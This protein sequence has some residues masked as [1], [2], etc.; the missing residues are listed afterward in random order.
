MKKEIKERILKLKEQGVV[1]Y[2]STCQASGMGLSAN[3]QLTISTVDTDEE[4]ELKVARAEREVASRNESNE[5]Y[6]Y[7]VNEIHPQQEEVINEEPV[8]SNE[9]KGILNKIISLLRAVGRG[10]IKD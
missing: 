4:I 2:I 6:K 5:R 10:A 3:I 9:R 1:V 7:L 8:C